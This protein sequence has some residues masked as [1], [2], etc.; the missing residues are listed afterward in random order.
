MALPLTREP[1]LTWEQP[2]QLGPRRQA[3]V[4]RAVVFL[5]H[6]RLMPTVPGASQVRDCACFSLDL[7]SESRAPSVTAPG[8]HVHLCPISPSQHTLLESKD[9]CHKVLFLMQSLVLRVHF[10]NLCVSSQRARDEGRKG[11]SGGRGRCHL[12]KETRGCL[13][14][15]GI[16]DGCDRV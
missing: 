15:Q 5:C 16:A 2:G 12:P 6:L 1:G 9:C 13:C 4:L 3:Q 8:D 11:M 10:Y 14:F 7:G